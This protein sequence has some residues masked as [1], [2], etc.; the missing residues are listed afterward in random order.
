[1]IGTNPS[2]FTGND[3]RPVEC[4]S[5]SDALNFCNALSTEAGLDKC[6]D[7]GT[8]ACDFSKSGYRLPTEAEWEYA[9]RAGTSTAYYTGNTESDL[10]SAGWYWDNW[11]QANS[12]THV[13]GEKEPNAF[14]LYDMHGNVMEL[15]ND[16]YD[17]SYYL[18][19]PDVD[20]T[21]PTSGSNHVGRGGSYYH[22]SFCCQSAYRSSLQLDIKALYIGF[23]AVRRP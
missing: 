19:S 13:V 5:W 23:R 18:S 2:Y 12:K 7:E 21:G 8:G 15:C 3:T 14:G 6:Y 22:N 20:P 4:V 17:G 16:W 11:G 1:V 9:C 10:D